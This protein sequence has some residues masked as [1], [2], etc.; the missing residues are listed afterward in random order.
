MF[1]N[2]LRAGMRLE[3]DPTVIYGLTGGAPLGHGLRVCGARER[4]R[5]QHLSTGRPAAAPIANPGEAAL[6]AVLHPARTDDLYFVADGTGGHVFAATSPSTSRN[7]ARWRE[8]E[9]ARGQAAAE[10]WRLADDE[11]QGAAARAA[12]W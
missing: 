7:V 9:A 4:E 8:I 3:S 10:P 2:R 6:V 12:C 5:L 11:A 1:I